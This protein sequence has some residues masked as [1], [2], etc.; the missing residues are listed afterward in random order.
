MK[1]LLE[2]HLHI[3]L[4][5]IKG[6]KFFWRVG[7]VQCLEKWRIQVDLYL[8]NPIADHSQIFKTLLSINYTIQIKD[9]PKALQE[10]TV[11]LKAEIE[12]AY[13]SRRSD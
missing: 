11:T 8:Q 2:S 10:Y 6:N 13:S 1:N 9:S 12:D 7:G 5:A 3:G 4:E